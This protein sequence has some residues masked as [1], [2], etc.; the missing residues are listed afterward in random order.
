MIGLEQPVTNLRSLWYTVHAVSQ[1]CDLNLLVCV[2]II[3]TNN[4][5][6]TLNKLEHYDIP[7]QDFPMAQLLNL[8]CQ[9]EASVSYDTRT[10]MHSYWI[11]IPMQQVWKAN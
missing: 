1:D 7:S 6:P 9:N 2:N 3:F 8:M 11:C 5:N 10:V 4:N